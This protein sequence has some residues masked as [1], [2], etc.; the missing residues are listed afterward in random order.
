[1]PHPSCFLMLVLYLFEFA[2]P[3][4]RSI[5][6]TREKVKSVFW[7]H[8]RLGEASLNRPY[9]SWVFTARASLLHGKGREAFLAEDT[10]PANANRLGKVHKCP[11]ICGICHSWNLLIYLIPKGKRIYSLESLCRAWALGTALISLLFY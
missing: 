11:D 1:M 6:S 2:V 9:V 3:V 7:K 4:L 8:R 5:L 10:A